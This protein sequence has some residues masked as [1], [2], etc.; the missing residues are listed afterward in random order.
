MQLFISG[1]KEETVY[2]GKA[3]GSTLSVDWPQFTSA[4]QITVWWGPDN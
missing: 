1:H 4:K 2:L 3:E